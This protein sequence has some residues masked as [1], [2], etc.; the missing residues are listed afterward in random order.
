MQLRD[1]RAAIEEALRAARYLM[2]ASPDERA[3]RWLGWSLLVED[4]EGKTI[5]LLPFSSVEAV[6]TGQE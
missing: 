2:K 3:T 4:A 5:F 1:R 6:S